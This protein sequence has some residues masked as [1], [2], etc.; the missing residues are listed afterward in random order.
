MTT[1]GCSRHSRL[2]LS[3]PLLVGLTLLVALVV[4]GCAAPGGG[5]S[6]RNDVNR[7]AA[8]LPLARD[9]V[10]GQG[11]LTLVRPVNRAEVDAIGRQA[12][13]PPE[14]APPGSPRPE[15]SGRKACLVVYHGDYPAGSIP[16]AQPPTASGQFALIVL[17]VR[18]PA[19]Y[20]VLVTNALPAFATK[21]P[22]WSF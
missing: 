2:P 4:D 7:C 17:W 5:A 6:T 10:H 1:T 14:P 8:V 22:W 11:T 13:A 21:R 3:V 18:H 16:S 15:P 12:G 9:V 20:R 19:V